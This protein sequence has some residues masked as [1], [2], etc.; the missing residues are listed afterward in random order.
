MVRQL[1]RGE[2]ISLISGEIPKMQETKA[3]VYKKFQQC[4][5][6]FN[7]ALIAEIAKTQKH[8]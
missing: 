2:D 4:S 7:F 3:L 8:N 6:A 5:I 1:Y